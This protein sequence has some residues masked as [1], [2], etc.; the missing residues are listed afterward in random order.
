MAKK[1]SFMVKPQ[2]ATVTSRRQ[3]PKVERAAKVIT[4]VAIAAL[5]IGR[6]SRVASSVAT[7]MFPG[8]IVSGASKTKSRSF[9][10]GSRASIEN[11]A[12][13]SMGGGVSSPLKGTKTTVKYKTRGMT[14]KQATS[15]K[16]TQ[17]SEK[18]KPRLAKTQAA[19]GTYVATRPTKSKK[20]K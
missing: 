7:K 13:R 9:T 10:Q 11:K 20:K 15:L 17:R 4:G 1:K 3:N 2:G 16:V 19:V 6:V 18:V 5:P 14:A 8:K 12:S